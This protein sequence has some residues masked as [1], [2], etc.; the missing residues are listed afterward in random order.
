MN[1]RPYKETDKDFLVSLSTRF[2]ECNLMG[3][4]DPQKMEEAQL[5][6]AKE[7]LNDPSPDTE[8]FVAEEETGELLGFLEVKPHKD[9]LSGIEQGN[10]VAI[11][12]SSK[13]EGKGIGKRLMEKA[14]E[15]AHQNGYHQLVLNVFAKNDRAVN[16]YKHLN[17]E[18][19]VLKMVK[20]I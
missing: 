18:T 2:A 12:V 13:G 1:I 3:W 19:E 15:W 17:Y 11:A 7:S 6:I 16:F 14:E 10:I 8:I 20:E 5:K 9:F 4:R